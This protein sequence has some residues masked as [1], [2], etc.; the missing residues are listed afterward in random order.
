[1]KAAP[2]ITDPIDSTL[3]WIDS[4]RALDASWMHESFTSKLADHLIESGSGDKG[5]SAE[6]MR[7]QVAIR[8]AVPV[9]R[10]LVQA[11]TELWPIQ[12]YRQGL[13]DVVAGYRAD[14]EESDKE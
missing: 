9:H 1:M 13:V 4:E 14:H 6:S 3:D 12:R 7:L 5:L 2:R 8:I 10:L 11:A